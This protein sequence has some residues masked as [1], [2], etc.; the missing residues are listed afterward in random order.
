MGDHGIPVCRHCEQELGI[1][2]EAVMELKGKILE[3]NNEVHILIPGAE[4]I[5]RRLFERV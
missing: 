1:D 4:K 3:K 2:V 5:L